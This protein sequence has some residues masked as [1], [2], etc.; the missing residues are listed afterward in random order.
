M[1]LRFSLL[2]LAL[3]LGLTLLLSASFALAQPAEP[4]VGLPEQWVAPVAD[5]SLANGR[6]TL[7]INI[8]AY[9]DL[10]DP[11]KSSFNNEI[12]HLGHIYEGLTRLDTQLE[13]VPGAAQGWVYSP[14]ATV[15][16]FTLRPGLMYSD[17][18]LLN[19]MRYRFSIL[20]NIDP[21]THGEYASITD[22]ILGA[23]A[24]RTADVAHLTPEQLAAL[25][26][27][28]EVRAL[29]AAGNVCV[30]YAQADCLTLRLMF[31]APAPY[32]HT[33]MSLWVTYPAKEELITAGG[34]IWWQSPANQIG[35]GPF[36]MQTLTPYD[37]AY[38]TPNARYWRGVA[39]YDIEYRYLTDSAQ[40][41]AA[42]RNNQ[43][44]IITPSPADM[45]AIRAD[46]TLSKELLTYSGSCSYA[47]MFHNLKPPFT[48]PKVRQAFAYA[49]D[50]VA[51]VRDVLG[52]SGFPTLTWIP[53]G[54]PGYDAVETRWAYNPVSATQAISDS[55]Y[56]SIAALPPITLTFSSSARN[57]MRNEWLANQ[58]RAVLGVSLTLNSVD[59]TTYTELTKDVKTAPQTYI[60]GWC[61]DYPDPQNW[62]SVYWKTG[63]FAARIGYSNP[64]LDALMREADAETDPLRRAQLYADAQRM[65]VAD[66]PVA[67]AWNNIS[68]FLVTSRVKGGVT[69]PQDKWPG[70]GDPLAITV[71]PWKKV[72]LPLMLKNHDPLL[73]DNFDDPSWDG[74]YDPARWQFWGDNKIQF[75]QQGG[76]LVLTN[77]SSANPSGASLIASR[78]IYRLWPKVKELQARLKMSSDRTGG[79][80]PVQLS[81][82]AGDINGHAWYANC[83]LGGSSFSAQ[84]SARCAIFTRQG[85]TYPE[86]Y[87]TA[88]IPVD[89]DIWHT[90]RIETD[91]NSA[92]IRFLLNG[93]LIGAH[94]PTDAVALIAA[95]N[96]EVA[97]TVWGDAPNAT[98]TRYVDD[99]R[100]I[101]VQ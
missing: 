76:A 62:L 43:L 22:E 71:E 13:T 19:A 100:I 30:S 77:T 5:Q 15:L 42:Y 36:V 72:Y 93:T 3:S 4:I 31:T 90:F 66:C 39:T 49:L 45:A 86:E 34:D 70:W 57:Q 16:T 44:D 21:T 24:W 40:A 101:P 96:M 80:S 55:S 10:I 67:F 38:F 47:I 74:A 88:T 2:A 35:N 8:G 33:V 27:A 91:P 95:N 17:G 53:P 97:I 68:T 81:L 29:D 11:Q 7:R 94:T 18:T 25:K 99:V 37:R 14:D 48:D 69:T 28:V 52:G 75:R 83:T 50:R 56:G 65:L 58:W 61:A 20:R 82:Y 73:Y 32:F 9:P 41:L 79:W 46:P 78:P 26:A 6:E 85:A 98:A 64:T 84:A 12:A 63:A 87:G 51:W 60:L 23:V 54:Y 92:A 89:L 59:P 1:K